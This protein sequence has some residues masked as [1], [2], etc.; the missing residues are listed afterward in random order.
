[1]MK[2]ETNLKMQL[3]D[4]KDTLHR[5]VTCMKMGGTDVNNNALI[6]KK[7]DH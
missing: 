6:V 3:L 5:R 4:R 1:M 2:N 7:S